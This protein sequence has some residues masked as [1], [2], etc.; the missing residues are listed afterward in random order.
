MTEITAKEALNYAF[1]GEMVKLYALILLGDLM[2]FGGILLWSDGYATL[3][4]QLLE[5]ASILTGLVLGIGAFVAFLY[6]VLSDSL[7]N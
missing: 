1:S 2:F 7:D 3:L 5:G 6:K 4:I